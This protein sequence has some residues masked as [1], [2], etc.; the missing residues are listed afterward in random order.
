MENNE[1]QKMILLR[2]FAIEAFK[3]LEGKGDSVAMV[4]Q[5]DVAYTLSSIVKRID[6]LLSDYVK[7]D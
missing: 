4:K 5:E 7:F 6:E 3:S 1:V 2:K